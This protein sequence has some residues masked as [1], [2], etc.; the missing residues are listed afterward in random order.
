MLACRHLA[1]L[2]AALIASGARETFRGQAWS[3]NC[4]EWVYFDV[5]LDVDALRRRFAFGPEVEMHENRDPRSGLERGF[6][7]RECNDAVMGVI[8][9][10][11]RFR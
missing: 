4:R 10:A 5:V 1:A 6:V 2:E 11:G 8:D 9:G 7:C 3:D